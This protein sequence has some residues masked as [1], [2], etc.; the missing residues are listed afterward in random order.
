MTSSAVLAST[1]SL[2]GSAVSS[3]SRRTPSAASQRTETG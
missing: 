3:P 1:E 2:T